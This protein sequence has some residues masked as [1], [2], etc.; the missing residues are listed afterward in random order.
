MWS[1]APAKCPELSRIRL[2]ELQSS[3][4]PCCSRGCSRFP[5]AAEIIFE[6][7][8]LRAVVGDDAVWWSLRDGTLTLGGAGLSACDLKGTPLPVVAADGRTRIPLDHCR[9]TLR[10]AGLAPDAV[11]TLLGESRFEPQPPIVPPAD[12]DAKR[13]LAKKEELRPAAEPA[14]ARR[15]ARV[16]AGWTVQLSQDLLDRQPAATARALELLKGQLEEINRVVPKAA[17]VELQKVTLWI[18]PEYPGV[19]PR[20][21]YHPDAGWL[22]EHGRDPAMVRSVEFT[23]VRIFEAET[24]RMPNFALHELA[25]AYHDRVLGDRPCR[26]SRPPTNGPRPAASTTAWNSDSATGAPA[27]VRAYAMASPQ[28]YFAENTEAFFSRNDFFPFT[29]DELKQHDPEMFQLLAKLWGV[30]GAPSASSADTPRSSNHT[31]KDRTSK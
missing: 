14:R 25:H 5:R 18:S 21:E 28:E 7:A 8:R 20:A 6:N 17:V 12:A 27:N 1:L 22:R 4:L 16:I 15:E 26:S 3:G 19:K 30:A 29:R 10:F 11:R 23:N 24:R 13:G 2:R 31:A 9:V